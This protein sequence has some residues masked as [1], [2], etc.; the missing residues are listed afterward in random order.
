[1]AFE[2]GAGVLAALLGGDASRGDAGKSFV[3]DGH[4]ALLF[5][6]GRHRDRY[7]LELSAGKLFE[8]CSRS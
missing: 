3:E 6:K 7:F 2:E 4:D 8:C 5:V 1:M